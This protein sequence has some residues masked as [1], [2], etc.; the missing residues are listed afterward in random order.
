MDDVTTETPFL[1]HPAAMLVDAVLPFAL[2]AEQAVVLHKVLT[3]MHL[4][5][6][7]HKGTGP[8]KPCAFIIVSTHLRTYSTGW[9]L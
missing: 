5:A 4:S 2:G 7:L 3:N 6:A 1:Q 9:I 8:E